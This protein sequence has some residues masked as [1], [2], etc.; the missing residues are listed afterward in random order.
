MSQKR[1]LILYHLVNVLH[2]VFYTLIFLGLLEIIDFSSY[3]M[4]FVYYLVVGYGIIY[5]VLNYFARNAG[6][7]LA[8]PISR[9]PLTNWLHAGSIV[10]FALSF[11]LYLKVD[12]VYVYLMAFSFPMDI[13]A[14]VLAYRNFPI[15]SKVGRDTLDQ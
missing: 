15:P 8:N 12:P 14:V 3:G 6:G 10:V 9:K 4:R 1:S 7:G 5:L 2:L 13:F 11:Y